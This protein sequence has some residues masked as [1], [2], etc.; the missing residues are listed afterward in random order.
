MAASYGRKTSEVAALR[1]SLIREGGVYA[2]RYG[3]V[4][5]A[6]PHFDDYVRRNLPAIGQ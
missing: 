5:F 6:I 1:D 2:P 3:W 4:E